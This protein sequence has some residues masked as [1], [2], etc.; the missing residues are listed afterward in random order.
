MQKPFPSAPL[1]PKIAAS[2]DCQTWWLT[3]WRVQTSQ[4]FL[5][6][7]DT[8]LN[9][10]EGCTSWKPCYRKSF[11][12]WQFKSFG[13]V[14][15]LQSLV[16]CFW[17]ES[18]WKCLFRLRKTV[19]I[20]ALDFATGS[21]VFFLIFLVLRRLFKNLKTKVAV[22]IPV[23][24]IQVASAYFAT[25]FLFFMLFWPKATHDAIKTTLDL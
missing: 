1:V 16:V 24:I 8:N 3:L 20:R 18:D 23:Q 21:P 2:N 13:K 22:L 4:I 17:M 12:D 11:I 7:T 6:A 10:A 15:R 5:S 14:P 25:M 9:L 19:R